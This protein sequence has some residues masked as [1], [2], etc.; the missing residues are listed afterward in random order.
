M[1]M[2]APPGPSGRPPILS[3]PI[4]RRAQPDGVS[5]E[6]E[7]LPYPVHDLPLDLPAGE[8]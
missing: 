6:P 5:G 2:A 8:G 4:A 1:V 3:G 7:R